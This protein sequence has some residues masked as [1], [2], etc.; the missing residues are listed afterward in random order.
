MERR[1]NSPEYPGGEPGSTPPDGR[2][3]VSAVAD[4]SHSDGTLGIAS[5]KSA[6]KCLSL[7]ARSAIEPGR[8]MTSKRQATLPAEAVVREPCGLGCIREARD[9]HSRS[10]VLAAPSLLHE[11][12]HLLGRAE[13]TT[14]GHSPGLRR[15]AIEPGSEKMSSVSFQRG[16]IVRGHE[17]SG[18]MSVLGDRDPLMGSTSAT[19]SN[20]RLRAFV[21][22]NSFTAERNRQIPLSITSHAFTRPLGLTR[23]DGLDACGVPEPL[24]AVTPRDPTARTDPGPIIGP[25]RPGQVRALATVSTSDLV[26]RTHGSQS[27]SGITSG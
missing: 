1:P 8:C 25:F 13:P 26:L 6:L 14:A 19:S 15:S 16:E 18:R 2:S 22:E 17:N 11:K 7:R 21:S 23:H 3:T 24:R 10:A 9:V 5:S 27:S 12:R 4:T 20:R